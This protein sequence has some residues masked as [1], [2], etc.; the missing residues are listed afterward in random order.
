VGGYGDAADQ[1]KMPSGIVLDS[2]SHVYVVD[3]TKETL[4]KFK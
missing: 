4:Q 2:L 1:F 3:A